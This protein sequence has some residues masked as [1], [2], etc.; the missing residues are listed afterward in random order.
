VCDFSPYFY[1]QFMEPLG[2]TDSSV[3]ASWDYDADDWRKDLVE[4]VKDLRPDVIRYGGLF[5]RY[6]RWREGVG[7]VKSRPWMRNF[8]WGGLETNRVGTHEFVNFCRRTGAEPLYCVNFLSDGFERY[9][10]ENRTADA[11]EAADWVSYANDPD[12]RERRRHGIPQPYNIKLWQLGNET[13]YG[14]GGFSRDEAI[15]RTIEFAKEMRG[16]DQ[17]IELI[18]W[19]D[20]D[21]T[22][23]FWAGEMWKRAGEHLNMIAF[24]MMGIG[25]VRKDSVLD[26]TRYQQD[27]ERAWQELLE[28]GDVAEKR[29]V[30]FE[31]IM[32]AARAKA[33]IAIT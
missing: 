7:P 20:R 5:C 12:S 27:P 30:A 15:A 2:V 18:G 11:R 4:T 26:G 13:S 29:L 33:W 28:C 3:E 16:R 6:Y 14:K 23:E 10:K 21:S 32:D 22:G 19:G 25:R 17:S 9:R 24:H 31:Q 8:V 1:M